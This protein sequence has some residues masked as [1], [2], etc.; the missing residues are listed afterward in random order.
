MYPDCLGYGER[1]VCCLD[2]RST[3]QGCVA[4]DQ[5]SFGMVSE[6]NDNHLDP[7]TTCKRILSSHHLLQIERF[8][9]EGSRFKSIFRVL[10]AVH[11]NGCPYVV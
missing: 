7:N 10:V 4:C 3:Y 5:C 2:D 8:K 6:T 9:V 11:D 1:R